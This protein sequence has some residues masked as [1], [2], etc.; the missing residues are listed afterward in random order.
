L[1]A[2]LDSHALKVGEVPASWSLP[3]LEIYRLRP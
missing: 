2:W 1:S 3:G